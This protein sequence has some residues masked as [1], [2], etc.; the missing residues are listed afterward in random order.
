[1]HH[2]SQPPTVLSMEVS[3]RDDSEYRILVSNRVRYLTISTG[4]FER[5]ILSMP[6]SSLPELPEDTTWN[7]AHVSRDPSSREVVMNLQHRALSGIT[8]LWHPVSIDCL[9]LKKRKSF[10]PTAYEVSYTGD[11]LQS[12]TSPVVIA[13]IARFEWEVPRLSMETFMYRR[14][15]NTGLAPRF[16][17]H[18]HEHGRVIGFVLEKIEGRE[19]NIEDL[20]SCQ[21][22]LQRL[23]DLGILHG[24]V[25]RHNFIVQDNTTRM[26]DF[27]NSK[28]CIGGSASMQAEMDSLRDQLVEET[29][30]GAGF[31]R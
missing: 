13:K 27:E 19:A 25:N 26:I 3:S 8:N 21:S 5:S 7:V 17:G 16:L 28:L 30:R 12:P 29:G 22:A 1:M 23:H 18:V 11:K 14:L 15:E 9:Q 4:T 10:T 2:I 24:D 20:P 6:L 31:A